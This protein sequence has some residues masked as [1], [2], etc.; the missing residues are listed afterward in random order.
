MAANMDDVPYLK[1]GQLIRLCREALTVSQ[2]ALADQLDVKQQTVD[3]WEKGRSRP[4]RTA[5]S[6]LSLHLGIEEDQLVEVGGYRVSDNSI[7]LPVTPLTRTL[8]LDKLPEERFEDLLVEIM[9]LIF[10]NGQPHLFGGRGHK[11]DGIDI[12]VTSEGVNLGTGQ[13]KRHKE[14]GPAAV[15]KAI[16]AVTIEAPKNYLFLSREIASP[17]ARKEA[18]RHPKWELWDGQDISRYIRTLSTEVAVR[19]VDTYFPGYREP[20]LG[21]ANPSPWLFAEEYF[22]V[23]S[24][25][26][27]NHG[28]NLA[29]REKELAEVALLAFSK[30]MS[31]STV[32]GSGGLGKTRF[33]KALCELAPSDFQV[34]ILPGDSQTSV[35]DFE[36]LPQVSNLTVMID[37]VHEIASVSQIISG[38]WRR[39]PKASIVL[40][41]RPYGRQYL[42]SDLE[43][44]GL[45]P[46][47]SVE[48]E[49]KDLSF[50]E[51]SVLAREALGEEISERVVHRLA[52]LT[53][54]FPLITVVGGSL[55]RQKELS[56]LSLEQ[57]GNVQSTILNKFN[58]VLV[59]DQSTT[60]PSLRRKVLDALSVLQPFRSNDQTARQSLENIVGKPFDEIQRQL[61]SLEEA[62]I[63]RR[64]GRSIR[65]VPDLLG[66]IILTR[67]AIDERIFES[68]GYLERIE[69]LI[70]GD[71][72]D[73]LFVNASRVD[74]QLL[75][76][77]RSKEGLAAPLWDSFNKRIMVADLVDRCTLLKT[78]EKVAYFQPKRV[79]EI[80]RWVIDNPTNVVHE[81]NRIWLSIYGNDYSAVLNTLPSLLKRAA[82]NSEIL[83]EALN[84]LWTLAQLDESS[85]SSRSDS[86]LD[87][88]RHLA[89]M[90]CTKPIWFIDQ[91]IDTASTWF[92]GTQ[93]ISPFKALEPILATE[94]EEVLGDGYVY[95]FRT[96]GFDPKG[97]AQVRQKA[98][99]LAFN[100][101]CSLNLQHAG[102]A[103]K[104]IG[105][106]IQY[107][108]GSI[109]NKNFHDGWTDIF[110]DIIS[111][112]GTIVIDSELDPAII[113]S[114]REILRW[115][116]AYGAGL[117]HDAARDLVDSLPGDIES[118]FAFAL[119]GNWEGFFDTRNEELNSIHLEIDAYIQSVIFDL[120]H[121]TEIEVFDLLTVRLKAEKEVFQSSAIS[122]YAF[123]MAVIE[124]LPGIVPK[125]LS[126]LQDSPSSI[127]D[128]L[129][130]I[131]LGTYAAVAPGA[132]FNHIKSLISGEAE[133]RRL[134]AVQSLGWHRSGRA[135]HP[136]EL[137]LII[138]LA[139]DP[140]Q[141]VRLSIAQVI[142]V[143]A[144]ES[145]QE[146]KQIF[147][148]FRFGEDAVLA[149]KIFAA[150]DERAG[151]SWNDFSSSELDVMLEDLIV[152]PRIDSTWVIKA[153]ADRSKLDPIWIVDLLKA[154]V[155]RSES[156]NRVDGYRALPFSW[157]AELQIRGTDKFL[158]IIHEV[159]EWVAEIQDSTFQR[160]QRAELFAA[161]VKDFDAEIVQFLVD[162]VGKNKKEL[163]KAIAAVLK[164]V[165]RTFVWE[166]SEFVATALRSAKLM[167]ND[168]L[169]ALMRALWDATTLGSRSGTVGEP[170]PESIEQRDRS[171]AIASAMKVGSIE[172]D[173]YLRLAE[174]AISDIKRDGESD[175]P[176]DGRDW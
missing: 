107:S 109:K 121:L 122:S 7:S 126:S 42:K 50:E 138:D 151:L 166:Y 101:L 105:L 176:P 154:R 52:G 158:P 23:T 91:I 22:D 84:I 19:I 118:R 38:I 86:A 76:Q 153:L 97:V 59:T 147:V 28:W 9:R 133:H 5:L 45:I 124:N 139:K 10:P 51:A 44:N 149:D 128:P 32:I 172:R 106:A 40:A 67:A 98:I 53:A 20:F 29:G 75:N 73:H 16:D 87:A 143:L 96:Y 164:Q 162:E 114:I 3:G 72:R 39:N 61:R 69:P 157:Q 111:R 129:L 137:N 119:H 167:G 66:D 74:H 49:L 173:F 123:L 141:L 17:Q 110:V 90:E 117:A 150:F 60:D 31:L 70:Q 62:G 33:L 161:I 24:N 12:L 168:V 175:S 103:V 112:L 94:A 80:V 79:L 26:L 169:S 37:D 1:L 135:L 8:P 14:F 93:K 13:C 148:A 83:P 41:V 132:A 78:L 25:P 140:E 36:L 125:I 159:L 46:E 165:P 131:I 152:L 156:A 11:Q 108:P 85:T 144:R 174:S 43:Q 160:E 65:I 92:S 100:E 34:R 35:V 2:S 55:I 82:F 155:L 30:N 120:A 4:R 77:D 56:L 134:A 171:Q 88:I 58:D 142:P 127:Y 145:P 68:T 104:F 71:S 81:E 47:S 63:L 170:Y 27:F 54:D 6:T 102:D 21:V 15:R 146:A 18:N 95:T 115:H 57:S 48:V 113:V 130:S 64:R 99:D 136:G 163:T 116:V 89:K